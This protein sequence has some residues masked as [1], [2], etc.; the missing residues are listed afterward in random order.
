MVE[1]IRNSLEMTF[2][3]RPRGHGRGRGQEDAIV[4]LLWELREMIATME[5]WVVRTKETGDEE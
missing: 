5:I 1:L 4:K 3:L 2:R